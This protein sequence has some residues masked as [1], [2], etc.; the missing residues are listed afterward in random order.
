[1]KKT[2]FYAFGPAQ[3]LIRRNLHRKIQVEEL[4][5]AAGL[6]V[7][8]FPR[9]FRNESG[10]PPVR[11]VKHLRL[12]TAKELLEDSR[13]SVKEVA[14]LVGLDA[15]RLVKEFRETFGLTPLRY[16]RLSGR[17]PENGPTVSGGDQLPSSP[18]TADVAES[19]YE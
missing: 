9:L 4:A 10:V 5:T 18:G 3:A 11:Y 16:R 8:R 15:S 12:Q 13:L 1:M 7:S 6:S 14:G 19:V 2:R 17:F